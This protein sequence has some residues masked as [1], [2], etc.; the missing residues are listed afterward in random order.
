MK[1]YCILAVL[2]TLYAMY[3]VL[4]LEQLS[5]AKVDLSIEPGPKV[6]TPSELRVLVSNAATGEPITNVNIAVEILIAE[7]GVKL[8]SGEFYSRDGE[9]K[10]T[11]HFQDASEHAIILKVSPTETSNYQFKP[12]TKTFQTEVDLPDPPTKVWFK[13]WAF[14]MGTMLL[15]I[16]IGFYAVKTKAKNQGARE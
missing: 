11:Y 10:M 7:E 9:L 5:D 14:L 1:R 12:M 2:I 8:F 3:P 15:G 16:A 4:A 13:T 6:G